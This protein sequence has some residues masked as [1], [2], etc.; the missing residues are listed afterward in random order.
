MILIYGLI[1]GLPKITKLIATKRK[2][3]K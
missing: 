2:K 3:W 1:V